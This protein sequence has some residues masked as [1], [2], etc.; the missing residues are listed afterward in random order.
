MFD[1]GGGSLIAGF[2]TLGLLMAV[3]AVITGDVSPTRPRPGRAR[4]TSAW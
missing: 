3:V 4:S 2:V 1:G